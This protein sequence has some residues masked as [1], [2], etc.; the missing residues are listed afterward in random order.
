MKRMG[1]WWIIG[2]LVGL[3]LVGK[4]GLH[5]QSSQLPIISSQHQHTRGQSV[6]PLYRG[7]YRGK[8]MQIYLTF[9][10]LNRNS[11]ERLE[12]PIGPN[13]FVAPG[14]ADQGQPTQFLPGH[15]HGVFVVLLP[16]GLTTEVTWTLSSRGETFTMPANLGPLYEIEGL[17]QR[18]G[19]FPGNTPPLVQFEA[20]GYA[21]QGPYGLTTEIDTTTNSPLS[22]DVWVSDDGL[23]PK[24]GGNKVIRSLQ[25]SY[26]RGDASEE[27]LT[28]TWSKY[29][30][31]GTV[32]FPDSTPHVERGKAST[33]ATFSEPGEYMLRGL[34]S[35][36][37]GF[38]GCCWTNAYVKVKVGL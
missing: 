10:Y 1:H 37:S 7:W 33:S 29:R 28:I 31:P 16:R 21:G 17:I 8:D 20:N 25:R 14:L 23:P 36:G 19:S 11:D 22:L 15:Q 5:A 38:D 26:R 13:N 2:S 30:G 12:I 18:G 4:L 32:S 9:E 34:V 35:D 3:L 24:P 6:V 27:G